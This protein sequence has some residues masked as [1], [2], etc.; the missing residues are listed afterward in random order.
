MH[1]LSQEIVPLTDPLA[2]SG[3]VQ[4][5]THRHFSDVQVVLANVR[6]SLLRHKFLESVPILGDV[7]GCLQCFTQHARQAQQERRLACGCI[8][9]G[10]QSLSRSAIPGRFVDSKGKSKLHLEVEGLSV[11]DYHRQLT[12]AHT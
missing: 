10:G 1:E 4:S 12:L 3:E 8:A 5:L 9:N 11:R 7:T 2:S 6:R